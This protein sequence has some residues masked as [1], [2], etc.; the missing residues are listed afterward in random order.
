M[1]YPEQSVHNRVACHE[2]IRRVGTLP[3]QVLLRELRGRE[4]KIAEQ[5]SDAPVD[6][7]GKRLPFVVSAQASLDVSD[8]HF[9]VECS[10]T[11]S[12]RRG[13][14]ALHK[15]PLGAFPLK[16]DL[17]SLENCSSNPTRSLIRT[18][19]LEIAV[20]YDAEQ[21]ER[22]VHHLA[23]LTGAADSH[24]NFIFAGTVHHCARRFHSALQLSQH[25][26]KL[27]GFGAS[28]EDGEGF[29]KSIC[30]IPATLRVRNFRPLCGWCREAVRRQNRF[31]DIP[32]PRFKTLLVERDCPASNRS[33]GE[34]LLD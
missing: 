4:M 13:R 8:L 23:M 10:Q 19:D 3:E 17:E 25:W 14:V 2:D 33:P 29:H 27:D 5:T 34:L 9:C 12:H 7:F 6:L 20:R 21:L 32:V 31:C 11:G 24:S 22:T 26:R 15:D 18:H 16:Q 1:G 30:S 28:S